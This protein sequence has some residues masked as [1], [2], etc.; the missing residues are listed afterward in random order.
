MN[1]AQLIYNNLTNKDRVLWRDE[2]PETLKKEWSI[3]TAKDSDYNFAE[4]DEYYSILYM[5]TE[6]MTEDET[7]TDDDIYATDWSDV[8]TYDRLEW[9]Q[10]NLSR[11][12]LYEESREHSDNLSDIIGYMQTVHRTEIAVSIYSNFLNKQGAR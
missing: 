1:R 11:I 10:N 4:L 7:F 6:K 12:D 2:T 8:S 9:L 3:F 5:L